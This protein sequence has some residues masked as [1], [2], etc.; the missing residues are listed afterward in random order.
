MFW[1]LRHGLY[2]IA[3]V[4]SALMMV[5]FHKRRARGIWLVVAVIA[6]IITP[7]TLLMFVAK[8]KRPILWIP[9]VIITIGAVAVPVRSLTSRSHVS[10]EGLPASEREP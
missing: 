4:A 9:L 5:A 7:F 3:L 1:L 2:P 8:F 6:A 10:V